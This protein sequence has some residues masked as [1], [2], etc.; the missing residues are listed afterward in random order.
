[1]EWERGAVPSGLVAPATPIVHTALQTAGG[2]GLGAGIATRTTFFDGPTFTAAGTPTIGLGPGDIGLAHSV[3]EHVPI[4]EL[5]RAAQVLAVTA[6]RFCGL[7]ETDN[8]RRDV[9]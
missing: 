4:D 3:D 1:M 5:V 2:L 6:M 8:N 7:A 9:P